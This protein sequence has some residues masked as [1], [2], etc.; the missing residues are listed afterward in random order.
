MLLKLIRLNF[1][2]LLA[3]TPQLSVVSIDPFKNI[4]TI[5]KSNSINNIRVNTSR[6]TTIAESINNTFTVRSI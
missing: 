3:S 6:A 5:Q 4:I 1:V 2:N